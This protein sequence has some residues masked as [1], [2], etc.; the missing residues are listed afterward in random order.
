MLINT[1]S[2]R[3]KITTKIKRKK[4]GRSDNLAPKTANS[5][6]KHNKAKT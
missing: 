1:S 6:R 4:N 5:S 2:E 3:H